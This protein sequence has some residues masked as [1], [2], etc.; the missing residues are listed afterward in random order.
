MRDGCLICRGQGNADW[1]CS[2]PHGAGRAVNRMDTVNAFTLSRYKKEMQ[3]IYSTSISRD[4]LD[5]CPM[6]YK[7]SG[8]IMEQISPTAEIIGKLTPVYNFKSGAK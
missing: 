7:D 5:E 1:N 2:A 4:T 6:A 3:G 8:T